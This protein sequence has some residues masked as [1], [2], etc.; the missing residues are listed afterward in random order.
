[1]LPVGMGGPADHWGRKLT[2]ESGGQGSLCRA[3]PEAVGSFG[4]TALVS[5]QS[6]SQ[7]SFWDWGGLAHQE[8]KGK[9]T[10]PPAPCPHCTKCQGS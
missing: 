6:P 5:V 4:F 7:G 2:A 1:M 8:G 9:P 10:L 3:A